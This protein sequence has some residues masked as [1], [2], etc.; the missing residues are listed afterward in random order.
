MEITTKRQ[1]LSITLPKYAMEEIRKE[2][3]RTGWSL[4]AL[5]GEYILSAMY[6]KPNPDTIA[7]IEEAKGGEEMATVD[8]SSYGSFVKS[9]ME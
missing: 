7:A 5:A 4:S 9:I 2:A 8:T 3:K 1:R 6:H